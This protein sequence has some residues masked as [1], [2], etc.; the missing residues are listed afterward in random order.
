[1]LLKYTQEWQPPNFRE[2]EG[3]LF[4]LT[5]LLLA[6]V[7]TS[8]PVAAVDRQG[9]RFGLQRRVD[10]TWAIVLAAFMLLALQ[11]TRLVPL[12]GVIALPLLAGGLVGTWPAV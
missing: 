9:W 10:L 5:L 4:G 12:Y 6:L 7:G 1:P 3:Q 2:P 11:A 8:R